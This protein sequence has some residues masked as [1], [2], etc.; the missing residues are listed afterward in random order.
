MP[1]IARFILLLRWPFL[2]SSSLILHL[3]VA[4]ALPSPDD[5][6]EE[7]LRT[8]IIVDARSPIDGKPMTA[9]DY[10]EL[11]VQ[12][13]NAQQ[14]TPQVSRQLKRA[15]QLLRLRKFLYTIFPFLPRR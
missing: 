11:Q 10:A 6:P 7:V 15:V 2:V 14:T 1:F 13:E 4:V 3:A 12:L 9:K 8:E 5:I